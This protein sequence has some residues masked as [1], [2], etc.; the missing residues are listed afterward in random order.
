MYLVAIENTYMPCYWL[1]SGFDN[2]QPVE[3]WDPAHGQEAFGS[4]RLQQQLP[5]LF[6]CRVKRWWW[7]GP[8]PHLLASVL[9]WVNLTR[10]LKRLLDCWL[11]TGLPKHFPWSMLEQ[12]KFL[13]G[14][15]LVER[16]RGL[17]KWKDPKK[18]IADVRNCRK[19]GHLWKNEKINWRSR[20]QDF[21]TR[22]ST[23]YLCFVSC[24]MNLW[25][26]IKILQH[27]RGQCCTRK[28][29]SGEGNRNRLDSCN[30]LEKDYAVF[31]EQLCFEFLN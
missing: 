4:G 3:L 2:L 22:G 5:S 6:R 24:H 12:E 28:G 16:D 21:P 7:M 14:R 29:N 23:P 27:G 13:G 1:R 9:N 20:V 25:K 8:S 11:Q 31:R 17:I 30:R 26:Y 10:N 15:Q 19:R 18:S